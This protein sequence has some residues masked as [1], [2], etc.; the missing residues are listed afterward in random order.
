VASFP[1]ARVKRMIIERPSGTIDLTKSNIPN[2][3]APLGEWKY[4]SPAERKSEST[5]FNNTE[6]LLS[7]IAVL[8]T[9]K[10]VAEKPSDADLTKFGFLPKTV[11][12]VIIELEGEENRQRSYEFGKLTDDGNFV[13][14]RLG[15]SPLVVIIPKTDYDRLILTDLRDATILRVFPSK[16]TGFSLKGWQGTIPVPPTHEYAN[17]D[18]SWTCTSPKDVVVDNMKVNAFIK[19]IEV[20]RAVRFLGPIKPEYKLDPASAIQLSLKQDGKTI[21]V[22]I[23]AEI[24][25]GIHFIVSISTF[26]GEAFVIPSTAIRNFCTSPQ[27]LQAGK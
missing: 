12:K 3:A 10:V 20:L 11:S 23:G 22:M 15:G 18:G 24:D 2:P 7:T 26:P 6:Q 13:H 4:A 9:Q 8:R 1:N 19:N 17:K 21:D 27:G 16:L 25:K 5:D 14:T